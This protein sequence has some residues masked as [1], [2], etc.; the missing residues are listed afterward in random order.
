MNRWLN[1]FVAI[2]NEG[3]ITKA[4]GKMFVSP[5]ALLQQI[6][7]LEQEIGFKLFNRGKKGVGLTPAGEKFYHFAVHMLEELEKT[8]HACRTIANESDVIRIPVPVSLVSR[9]LEQAYIV[10]KNQHPGIE[11]QFIPIDL[12]VSKRTDCLLKGELDVIELYTLNDHHPQGVY[13]QKL[14][15]VDVWCMV[16]KDHPLAVKEIMTP[17][18]LD[19]T[20]IATTPVTIL[21]HLRA[22]MESN[23]LHGKFIEVPAD[24]YKIIKACEEGNVIIFL[25][26]VVQSFPEFTCMRLNYD[27]RI[28]RGL[29][30]RSEPTAAIRMFFD[31][32][33]NN[34][35][36][37]SEYR[38]NRPA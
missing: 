12:P 37:A 11:L 23:A 16:K 22:Y 17:E 33:L 32:I 18:D 29:A 13:F 3:N 36:A 26:D 2:A 30:C 15:D 38:A 25:K 20:C 1:S 34:I 5:Q 4:A 10:F 31:V 7:L 19:G 24:R 28:S 6:N 21:K 9:F 27:C 8:L 14:E 35:E